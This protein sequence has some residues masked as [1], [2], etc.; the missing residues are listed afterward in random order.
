MTLA[1][2]A[3]ECLPGAE[4]GEEARR[5]FT[6]ELVRLVPRLKT[7]ALH[8]HGG[9]RGDDVVQETLLRALQHA[10]T[11]DASRPL[12]PWLRA[13]A[14]RASLRR[15]EDE[16]RR[17]M[18][19]LGQE[20][21]AR[22]EVDAGLGAMDAAE[23]TR[24]A[25]ARLPD[26]DRSVLDRHY[27]RGLSVDEL[28]TQ[29]RVAPGTIK[30]RLFRAR[31]RLAWIGAALVASLGVALLVVRARDH[32]RGSS[33]PPAEL[34]ESRFVVE[35]LRPAERDPS[36]PFARIDRSRTIRT[37]WVVQGGAE[38]VGFVPTSPTL[39]Q[40]PDAPESPRR[41]PRRGRRR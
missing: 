21:A 5:A 3:P 20:V 40:V 38:P 26:V 10:A 28:A 2:N 17:S 34:F 16:G 13:I 39:P 18:L 14:D 23:A 6:R 19:P 36:A 12:W 41:A 24:A 35:H 7:Y 1:S 11:F 27:L 31:R 30:A 29:D 25:L 32:D 9:D 37:G 33:P 15:V 4:P 8:R 22:E